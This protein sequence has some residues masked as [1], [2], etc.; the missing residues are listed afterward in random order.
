MD[1]IRVNTGNGTP[2][3]LMSLPGEN[4]T[5]LSRFADGKEVTLILETPQNEKWYAVYGQTIDGTYKSGWCSGEYLGNDVEYGTLVDVDSL[6]VR[7][8]AGTSYAILGTISKGDTVE[9]LEKDCETASG[10]TWHKILYNGSVGY[11][12]AGN[13]TPNFTF[14]TRWVALVSNTTLNNSIQVMLNNLENCSSSVIPTSKKEACVAI[15]RAMFAEG[16]K[17]AFVAGMLS[18]LKSEG[19]IGFFESSNYTSHPEEKPD[20][21]VYMDTNYNGTN[22]Y[23]INYS[24]KTIMDVNVIN[25]YNMLSWLKNN[26][27]HSKGDW[28]IGSSRV[29]FGLG[30]LQWTFSRSFDLIQRYMQANNNSATITKAQAIQAETELIIYELKQSSY[31][32]IVT[33]WENSCSNNLTSTSAANKAASLLCFNYLKPDETATQATIRGANAEII[34][35]EMVK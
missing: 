11:V 1:R 14:E 4:G 28:R 16:Y 35:A 2:L 26:S 23:R 13:N 22:F 10:Y 34:Y 19:D 17:P 20:Y 31:K 33:I 21:L 6:N 7:S 12:V 15:A 32:N 5:I 25:V 27:D 24:G 8:G 3:N 18:N 9:I 30:C 29:G